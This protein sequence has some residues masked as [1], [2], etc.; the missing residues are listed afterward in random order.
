M[1]ILNLCQKIT[2]RLDKQYSISQGERES[3]AD[4]NEAV[5]AEMKCELGNQTR[6]DLALQDSC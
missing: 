2:E 5:Y 3:F 4:D 6:G 1:F